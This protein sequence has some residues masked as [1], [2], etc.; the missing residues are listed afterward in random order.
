MEKF[1]V[2]I[3]K[4]NHFDGFGSSSVKELTL[5]K[6]CCNLYVPRIA[7]FLLYKLHVV[8]RIKYESLGILIYDENRLTINFH[9]RVHVFLGTAVAASHVMFDYEKILWKCRTPFDLWQ[10]ISFKFQE[11]DLNKTCVISLDGSNNL[12]QFL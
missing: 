7:K 1:S 9:R 3:K 11:L 5:C 2:I 10:C 4:R 12:R 6:L 8:I